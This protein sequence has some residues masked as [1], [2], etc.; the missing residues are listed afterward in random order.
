MAN[1]T[2]YLNYGMANTTN[3][4]GKEEKHGACNKI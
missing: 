4:W 2:K 1:N 3:C